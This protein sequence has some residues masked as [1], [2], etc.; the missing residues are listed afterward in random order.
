MGYKR[1]SINDV[2]FGLLNSPNWVPRDLITY[3]KPLGIQIPRAYGLLERK[4]PHGISPD[5]VPALRALY[6]G[7]LGPLDANQAGFY[8]PMGLRPLRFIQYLTID[9]HEI[10]FI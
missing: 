5:F 8:D 1:L 3:T 2:T 4:I 7:R 9:S 10:Y 6:V